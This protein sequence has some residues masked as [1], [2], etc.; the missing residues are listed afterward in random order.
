[1][2]GEMPPTLLAFADRKYAYARSV[3]IFAPEIFNDQMINAACVY[4]K[5]ER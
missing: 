3:H 1:M 5:S 2:R 4:Q